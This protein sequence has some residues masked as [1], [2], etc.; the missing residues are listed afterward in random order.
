MIRMGRTH[1]SRR[2]TAPIT[3]LCCISLV[4]QSQHQF[5]EYPR[6]IVHLPIDIRRSGR[7]CKARLRGHDDVERLS[8]SWRVRKKGNDVE[9]FEKGSC[10]TKP[11]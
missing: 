4:S 9:E 6:S 8:T 3:S 1:H 10:A 2:Y 7:E 5:V 11:C